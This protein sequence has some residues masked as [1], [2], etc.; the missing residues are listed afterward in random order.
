MPNLAGKTRPQA[1][2]GGFPRRLQSYCTRRIYLT[3]LELTGFF[4]DFLASTEVW[5]RT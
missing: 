2:L 3:K 1:E 4:V 5:Q